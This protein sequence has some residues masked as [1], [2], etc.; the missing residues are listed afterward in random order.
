MAGSRSSTGQAQNF[1]NEVKHGNYEVSSQA[2]G[3]INCR[4]KDVNKSLI[5]S[6]EIV[7]VLY[8]IM[9]K[10]EEQSSRLALVSALRVEL[11]RARVQVGQLVQEQWY[12][13]D[14]IDVRLKR[15]SEEMEDWRR[16][17]KQEIKKAIS[18]LAREVKIERKMRGRIE[19]MN[20]KLGS[21]L[22]DMR[23]RL[24]KAQLDEENENVDYEVKN[25]GDAG[26]ENGET[27]SQYF[28]GMDEDSSDSE[29]LSID[30]NMDH[31]TRDL[32]EMNWQDVDSSPAMS[33][34]KIMSS[35][36]EACSALLKDIESKRQMSEL[37]EN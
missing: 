29:L 5:A 35:L 22:A 26:K 3:E 14:E 23:T 7:K 27:A 8:N 2:S 37:Q 13:A 16:K 34:D 18:S 30:L 32:K 10:E 24:E 6:N 12:D 25:E 19:R 20:I 21:E 11:D 4:L 17:G 28:D 31:S 36:R 9:S 33:S 15:F 1:D